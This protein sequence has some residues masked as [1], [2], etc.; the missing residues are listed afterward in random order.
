[1]DFITNIID[2]YIKY[3]ISLNCWNENATKHLRAFKKYCLENYPNINIL[4][5]EMVDTWCIK[6]ETEI[7]NSCNKRIM[8][9]SGLLKYTNS[10]NI[11]NLTIPSKLK[12]NKITY[13]PHPEFRTY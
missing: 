4:T 9:I 7:N 8:V 11:T 12:P 6:R 2:E 13:I 3:R 5:Q 1:M 10:R